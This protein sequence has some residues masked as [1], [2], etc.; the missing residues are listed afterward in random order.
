MLRST[1]NLIVYRPADIL[2]VMGCWESIFRLSKPSALI[3][4]KNSIPKLPGSSSSSVQMG[5]YIIKKETN[6][7]DGI[8]IATGSE[9]VSALQI[10]YDLYKNGLDLRVVSMPS[11]ELFLEM[12]DTYI[13]ETIPKNIKTIVIESSCDMLWHRFA[14]SKEYILGINDFCYGGVPIEVLQKMNY[15]YDSLKMKVESL[16]K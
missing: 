4:S 15:D 9:V 14:T 1:P 2:E 16:M 3:I 10:A 6:R 7:L 5:A 13:F 8:I 12:G 11:V